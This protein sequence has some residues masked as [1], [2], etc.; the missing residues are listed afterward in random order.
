VALPPFQCIL[1]PLASSVYSVILPIAF[2]DPAFCVFRD[3]AY[4]F[5]D[6]AFC[7]ATHPPIHFRY[8]EV[9]SIDTPNPGTHVNQL[10][11]PHAPNSGWTYFDRIQRKDAGESVLSFYTKRYS[12]TCEANWRERIRDGSVTLDEAVTDPERILSVNQKLAYHRSPWVEPDAPTSYAVLF[13][14]ESILVV[15]KPSG[16]PVLPGGNFLEKTL[17]SQVRRHYPAELEPAPIHRIGRGT[18]GIV[19]FAKTFAAKRT[20]SEDFFHGR[21]R[22]VYR[23]LV[24][25]TEMEDTFIVESPIGKVPYP[26]IGYV[27]AATPEGKPSRT[28][29][30]VLKRNSDQQI[31]LIHVDLITGRPHQIRIHLAAAGHPLVDDPL[32]KKGGIPLTNPSG[33]LPMPGDCGY[34][35]HAHSITFTHPE[36]SR[37]NTLTCQPPPLLRLPEEN[38][39]TTSP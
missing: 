11:D 20:L 13:E 30:R 32:Y 24:K 33:K 28:E 5:P 3:P 1:W 8:I 26:E 39:R 36:T 4:R 27:Y 7:S 2:R 12:H 10:N 34:H 23:T 16:L 35:L 29:C 6:P 22:K 17:L 15:A 18:S 9:V 21:I 38:G 25:G 19:L 14:D 37:P 31:S